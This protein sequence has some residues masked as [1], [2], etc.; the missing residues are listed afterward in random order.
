MQIRSRITALALALTLG[1]GLG[2]AG[3]AHADL[4]LH[5]TRIVF[6][7]ATRSAQVELI[8]NG[9]EPATY[10]LR[11]VNR[12]MGESG[13][14]TAV[15]SPQPGE[16]FAEPMLRFS[17]RQVTVP[18]GGAQTVRLMLKKEGELPA[19]E[20]RSHLQFDRVAD[21]AADTAAASASAPAA[22]M[23]EAAP[24]EIGIVVTALVGASMPII[25]RH[26]ATSAT[27]ALSQLRMEGSAL[28]LLFERSGNASVYGDLA[29]TFTPRGGAAVPVGGMGGVAVYAPNPR[30]RAL[31]PLKLPAGAALKDG[32]LAVVYRER[33]DQGGAVLARAELDLP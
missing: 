15:D 24:K 9:T 28:S 23:K 26:G 3:A 27:V 7:K 2:L 32:R 11:L 29:V 13:E 22:A 30:R 25:V 12:R 19:G 16:L 21:A 33:P 4:M 20:Y 14:F 31:L 17:P 10:R 18:P 5:P 6:D 1:L 8:N